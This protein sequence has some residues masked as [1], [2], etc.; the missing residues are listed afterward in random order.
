[1]VAKALHVL[2]I[3]S[4][5]D[6]T[7]AAVVNDQGKI[8]S[9][10]IWSQTD[11]HKPYG[12]VV[13]NVA[14]R[15]HAD[16]IESVVNQTLQQAELQVE[17]LDAIAVTKGPGLIG[18]L[19]V[20]VVFA[21]ALAWAACKPLYAIN[22][23]EGHALTSRLVGTCPFPYLLLLMS[24]G[25]TQFFLVR[26]LGDYEQL[27]TSLDDALGEIFD[28]IGRKLGFDY[29]GGP[30][31]EAASGRGDSKRFTFPKPLLGRKGCDFSFSGLKTA[32]AQAIDGCT[33]DAQTVADIAASFQ[34]TVAAVLRDR[35]ARAIMKARQREPHL[36][37]FVCSGGV[38][39][40]Q[41][42][43][44][45]IQQTVDEAGLD[46]LTLPPKLCTD[47]GA[48]IAWAGM[49][50][51]RLGRQGLGLNFDAQARWPLGEVRL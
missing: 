37:R 20:G 12:G 3:E 16:A 28:K 47:N 43:L 38:A 11:A 44:R 33:L 19:L 45:S 7:A 21:K 18:G 35:I 22:H 6:E 10:I 24:G 51:L 2:G 36:K 14:A 30:K 5:C 41:F 13:P 29:P 34:E 17:G 46:L 4:S 8:C 23:L 42:L 26:D 40:N 9:H 49:E 25:H 27:G 48:M 31:I 39:A 15:A 1:M 50:R 32:V